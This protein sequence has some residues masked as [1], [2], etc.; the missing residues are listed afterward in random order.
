MFGP[1]VGRYFIFFIDD[2]NMP[3]LEQYGAQ[4]PIELLRQ[5]MDH[6]GWYDRK[7]IGMTQI[8]CQST[9]WSIRYV[10]L[11]WRFVVRVFSYNSTLI[12][13]FAF[14]KV[15]LRSW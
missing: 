12:P 15:L 14:S 9:S 6:H 5:W 11:P 2:L 3:M 7:Q 10:Y 1:P 8:L 13:D 4:P